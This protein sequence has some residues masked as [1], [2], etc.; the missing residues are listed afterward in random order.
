ML[1]HWNYGLHLSIDA[2]MSKLGSSVQYLKFD[3]DWSFASLES[4][5]WKACKPDD[6]LLILWG[7]I[8]DDQVFIGDVRQ[9]VFVA[10]WKGYLVGKTQVGRWFIATASL[11][12]YRIYCSGV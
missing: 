5:Y 10:G 2:S 6:T 8:R 9:L 11:S 3:I 4:F 7:G 12:F 1:W